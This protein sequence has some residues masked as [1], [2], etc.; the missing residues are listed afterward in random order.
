MIS[1]NLVILLIQLAYGSR[2]RR[3]RTNFK[4]ILLGNYN[5]DIQF[6]AACPSYSDC[7]NCS[8]ADCTWSDGKC[9]GD[10]DNDYREDNANNDRGAEMKDFFKQ[11]D[12]EKCGDPLGV[13]TQQSVGNVTSYGF[14][15]S[16]DS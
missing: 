4:Y 7:F 2:S 5:T 16:D 15:A 3:S 9:H 11:Q 12:T 10:S 1:L 13:C 8:L 6:N 14:G